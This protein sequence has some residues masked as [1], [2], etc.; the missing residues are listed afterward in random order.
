MVHEYAMLPVLRMLHKVHMG[1]NEHM[2]R[3][4][5]VPS[6]QSPRLL[7]FSQPPTDARRRRSLINSLAAL[8]DLRQ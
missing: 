7:F 2:Y 3:V 1:H 8:V 6:S 4:Y 5:A